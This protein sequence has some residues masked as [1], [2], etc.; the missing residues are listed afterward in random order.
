MDRSWYWKA[1]LIV[2]I[3]LGAVYALVPTWTY[4]QLPAEQ[5]NEAGVFEQH[6][7]N[8]A[9]KR[10]LNLGLD[11]Q[12]GIHLVMGVEVDR[13]VREKA[14][15]RAEELALD[16]DRRSIKG[17]DVKGDPDTG[18]VTVSGP[19]DAVSKAKDEITAGYTDMYMRRSSSG[20][21]ELAMKDDAIKLL[22]ESAVDQ[23]VKA[24]RN[25]VDKWGV[26]EP[27]IAK[28]GDNAILVQLPGYSN[29]EKAK[30][31][32]GKTAQLEFKMVDDADTSLTQL[33]D[34]PQGITLDWDRYEGPGGAQVSSPYL[35]G[36]DRNQLTTFLQG[37]AP[38]GREFGLQKVEER[39]RGEGYYR[40]YTVDKKAGLTG[41]YITDA[42]VAFDNS[43]GEGNRP[44]VQVTFNRTGAEVFGRLTAANVK[45]RMAI[46]LDDNVDSAPVIQSEIP[47][48]VCSI[49]LG[50]LKPI[51][52]VLQEAKDLA[53]VLK[54]GALPA[55][56][57]ILEERSVGA[58]LGPE[59]I[60]RGTKAA[61]AGL[62]LVLL[63]MAAYYRFS[64][65]VADVAL[66]LNGIV[67]LAV[68]AL[69][70]STLTLPGIAGFVLTLGM[71][72]DANVL[73]NERIREEMK[74]GKSIATA[75][76]QGYD[77]VF[78]TIFD[79]HVTA[80]VAGFVIRA[81]G[82]GPVR[83]FATTLIIGLLASMF[84][85]IVVTRAIVE[86]FVGHG[87]L[88]KAFSV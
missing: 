39:G 30:E 47:G 1:G 53:L 79:G 73:I 63:F 65:F 44:Y 24:I 52:E 80:L 32:L 25:R 55:P 43:P 62:L 46:V 7:P 54:S 21:F 4:F 42:R 67:V 61:V 64:G 58:S 17:V 33:K 12:G 8:W 31:L 68:M 2:L 83:G 13:A 49:H 41:E 14:V 77:K 86:W 76:Q 36:K 5:R 78:W 23:A 40:T 20:S 84:T 9:P 66:V 35:R 29:P 22:K 45:K 19:A 60:R 38:P 70:D 18:I 85:S 6:R 75:V 28:K 59:L 27:T 82:S 72:V 87:K 37:K 51:N 56:V 15:R 16:L 88:H 57:R 81:Y 26:S 74:G 34:L 11:L 71:A 10:H 48:G 50:G 69:M 3:T